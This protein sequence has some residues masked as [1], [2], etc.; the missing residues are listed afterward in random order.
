MTD[1]LAAAE[2]SGDPYTIGITSLLAANVLGETGRRSDALAALARADEVFV[3]IGDRWGLGLGDILRALDLLNDGDRSGALALFESALALMQDIGD[4]WAQALCL[5]TRASVYEQEGD[6][7]VGA[8]RSRGR[9]AVVR[10]G[11]R[12]WLRRDCAGEARQPCGPGGRSRRSRPAA[13]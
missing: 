9:S 4:P 10:G 6:Y 3:E 13:R 12:R 11:E 1:A 8:G 2:E 7:V 5:S